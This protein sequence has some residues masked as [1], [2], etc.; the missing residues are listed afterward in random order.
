MKGEETE[1]N[2]ETQE[3]EGRKR[4]PIGVEETDRVD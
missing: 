4:R 3:E 1:E 2:K